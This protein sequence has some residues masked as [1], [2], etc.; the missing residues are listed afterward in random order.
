MIFEI[1]AQR[2][3]NPSDKKVFY[4]DNMKN[5]LKDDQGVVIEYSS[6]QKPEKKEFINFN[7]DIPLKNK[8]SDIKRI[9]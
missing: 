6:I 4:Y 3:E 8:R 5:I 2:Q 7:K 1:H 9:N